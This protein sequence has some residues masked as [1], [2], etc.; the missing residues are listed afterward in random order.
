MKMQLRMAT[1]L[2]WSLPHRRCNRLLRKCS[3]HPNTCN[4]RCEM[5]VYPMKVPKKCSRLHPLL[6][7]LLHMQRQTDNREANSKVESRV[8]NKL[9]NRVLLKMLQKFPSRHNLHQTQQSRVR[10]HVH[11]LAETP[12]KHMLLKS[13]LNRVQ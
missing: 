1:S 3:R 13:K 7:R 5:T 2:K 10:Q 11:R 9:N 12:Q 4:K 6:N 8:V